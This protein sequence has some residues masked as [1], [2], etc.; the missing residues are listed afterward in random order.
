L[1][2]APSADDN[3]DVA[4]RRER[5]AGFVRAILPAMDDRRRGRIG[6]AAPFLVA[7]IAIGALALLPDLSSEISSQNQAVEADHGQIQSIVP[8]TSDQTPGPPTAKV[9]IL[10]GPRQGQ[11]LTALLEGPGGSQSVANYQVG[12]EVVVTVTTDESG[13]PA[14]S[15]SDRWRAPMLGL[16]LLIFA[17]AVVAVGGIRGARSLL[18]LGL[19]IALIVKVLIP[20]IIVGVPPVPLAVVTATLV[21]VLTIGLTEGWS[22]TSAAAILGTASSL[23]LTGLL[24]AAATALASFTYSAGSDLAFLQTGNGQGLD[25]R[26][27]LLAAFILGAVGVLDDVTVT[28]AALVASLADHGARGSG[29]FRSA[30]DVG[31]S[32]IAAT[33]NTL[34]LAYIGAG[35]PLI[36]TI[37]V[38]NQPA[39]I[40]LNSEEVATE[41]VRT[42]V[43]S[44]GILAAVPLTTAIAAGLVDHD[45]RAAT[46]RR[47]LVLASSAG[48]TAA[49]LILT[50]VLPLGQGMPRAPLVQDSFGSGSVP[51]GSAPPLDV[52]F[53]SAAG[54]VGPGD[55]GLPGGGPD[56]SAPAESGPPEPQLLSV[57]EHY[58]L[59][60]GGA[61]VDLSVTALTARRS[62]SATE[63]TISVRYQNR[64]P[65]SIEVD[66]TAWGLITS[67]GED[68]TLTATPSN[69]LDAGPLSSGSLRVGEL[70]GKV[71]AT[72]DQT[73]VSF[74]D[75]NDVVAFVVPA[76]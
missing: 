64:G 32:H 42:L 1:A 22:R 69:G 14:I 67:S 66:P 58:T 5:T 11:V 57:R 37:L 24:G 36:V 61:S 39:A 63:I 23:A 2:G 44:L 9:V 71:N 65:G 48:A 16:F 53:P 43:G 12:D 13:Q 56:G 35:L 6:R 60:L 7:A 27:L 51:H 72:P 25:L 20:L 15:V 31:R 30:F 26:G 52:P 21:T 54:D 62:G 74:T 18:A 75:P 68:V 50:A 76:N 4:L 41:I 17:L 3:A 70:R 19:T 29:L 8:G 38:S 46:S 47:R 49:G 10:D 73:F 28:Q 59:A 45:G 33:V 34:F 40:V 55:S